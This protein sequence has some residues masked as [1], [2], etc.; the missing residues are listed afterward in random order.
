MGCVVDKVGKTGFLRDLRPS[1]VSIT[2]PMFHTPLIHS[3][4]HSLTHPPINCITEAYQPPLIKNTLVIEVLN[5]SVLESQKIL[6]QLGNHKLSDQST[7]ARGYLLGE[8]INCSCAEKHNAPSNK[9]T[10]SQYAWTN[11]NNTNAHSE[12]KWLLRS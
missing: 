6:N 1:P 2:T 9:R 3:F 10:V 11:V 5:L 8:V 4:I 7:A 12:S